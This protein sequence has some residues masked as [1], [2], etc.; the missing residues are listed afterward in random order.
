MRGLFLLICTLTKEYAPQTTRTFHTG[1]LVPKVQ[2]SWKLCCQTTV[3]CCQTTI[4][5]CQT[6]VLCCQTT[7]SIVYLVHATDKIPFCVPILL[8]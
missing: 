8:F 3:L 1:N 4:L 2:Y 7:V 6:T 5:C